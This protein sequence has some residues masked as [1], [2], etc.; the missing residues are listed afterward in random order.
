MTEILGGCP[1]RGKSAVNRQTSISVE[2]GREMYAGRRNADRRPNKLNDGANP[3]HLLS[4]SQPNISIDRLVL[5]PRALFRLNILR[6]FSVGRYRLTGLFLTRQTVCRLHIL[7]RLVW[8]AAERLFAEGQECRQPLR[9][10]WLSGGRF[11]R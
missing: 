3:F 8:G 9:I 1:S 5:T 7:C 2:A 6:S 10:H 11:L 4:R